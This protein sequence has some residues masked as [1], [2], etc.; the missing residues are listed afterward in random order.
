MLLGS[1]RI[2]MDVTLTEMNIVMLDRIDDFITHDSLKSR[3]VYILLT[4]TNRFHTVA[5]IIGGSP[6]SGGVDAPFS[7]DVQEKLL[8]PVSLR[9]SSAKGFNSFLSNIIYVLQYTLSLTSLDISS[10]VKH[11][12][13]GVV[14]S[15]LL[16]SRLKIE[17]LSRSRL[18][19]NNYSIT[20]P[21][22]TT[23]IISGLQGPLL[24]RL[25]SESTHTTHIFSLSLSLLFSGDMTKS[26]IKTIDEIIVDLVIF[27]TPY[28]SNI[29]NCTIR[30]VESQSSELNQVIKI[31]A[32]VRLATKF[33]LFGRVVL[34]EFKYN[35]KQKLDEKK[36]FKTYL[37]ELDLC[38]ALGRLLSLTSKQV[39]TNLIYSI[40]FIWH[41]SKFSPCFLRKLYNP[42]TLHEC[43]VYA[44]IKL[45]MCSSLKYIYLCT[46]NEAHSQYTLLKT[47]CAPSKLLKNVV[48]RFLD[49]ESCKNIEP[50]IG[51]AALISCANIYAL[52]ELST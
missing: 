40:L 17:Q 52:G 16:C 19:V 14:V 35:F 51:L 37:E 45:A 12:K 30:L 18:K 44:L 41:K 42:L 13:C 33:L 25:I 39:T 48:R 31:Y 11:M 27:D 21:T 15:C 9:D 20:E 46:H 3:K 22:R 23:K 36:T 26:T 4:C 50:R 29:I 24:L 43:I 1:T 49:I 47:N 10:H 28:L 5:P 38:N 7:Q 2:T 6:S 8:R 34:F 32:K